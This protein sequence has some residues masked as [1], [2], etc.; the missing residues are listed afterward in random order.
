MMLFHKITIGRD[1]SCILTE[2]TACLPQ[3]YRDGEQIS[4][5]QGLQG[6]SGGRKDRNR[7]AMKGVVPGILDWG[8]GYMNLNM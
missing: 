5:R 8:S 2:L 7:L 1:S 4:D 3:N 6:G